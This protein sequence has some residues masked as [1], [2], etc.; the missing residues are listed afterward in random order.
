MAQDPP[1]RAPAPRL[2]PQ[3]DSPGRAASVRSVRP[4]PLSQRLA[5]CCDTGFQRGVPDKLVGPQVLEELLPGDHAVAMR[6]Q[7]DE[8]LKDF[9]PQR[10][11][12]PSVM[13]LIALGIQDIVAKRVAHRSTFLP[14]L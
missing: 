13:Q 6:Q 9:A 4:P 8:H 1:R 3:S 2:P 11:R 7:V 10:E 12:L 14:P 5:Q